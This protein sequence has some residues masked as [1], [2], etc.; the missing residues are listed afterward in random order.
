MNTSLVS[1]KNYNFKS[2]LSK[3]QGTKVVNAL[4]KVQD[5]LSSLEVKLNSKSSEEL[6]KLRD[7]QQSTKASAST[8]QEGNE[9]VQMENLSPE[10]LTFDVMNC[11]LQ[12][13]ER[14]LDALTQIFINNTN[15][16]YAMTVEDDL[17]TKIKL[18]IKDESVKKI[19]I[20]NHFRDLMYSLQE[21]YDFVN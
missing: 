20:K 11:R 14:K 1:Q 15:H 3:T 17:P 16:G 2:G 6:D 9:H 19:F 4:I 18:Q 8:S 12:L 10:S 5:K 7:G 21:E 13:I